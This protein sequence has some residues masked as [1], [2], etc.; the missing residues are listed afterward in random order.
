ML[1]D[2]LEQLAK[3]RE[4]EAR[5]RLI[6]AL[7]AEYAK[8]EDLEPSAVERELFCKIVLSV[9]DQLDLEARYELVVRLAKTNRITSELADRLAEENYELSE[10]VIES[11]PVVSQKALMKLAMHGSNQ[12]RLSLARRRNL[13]EDVAD[14]LIARA[15]RPVT[16]AL[17]ANTT[18]TLSIKATLA[19]L[20]FANTEPRVLAGLARRAMVDEGFHETLSQVIENGCPLV[21]EP[22]KQAMERDALEPLA[23]S[24]TGLDQNEEIEIDGQVL[25]RHEAN[26]N[27]ASGE[28]SFDA[29]LLTLFQQGRVDA[30][31]WLISRN[32]NLECNVI[33]DTFRSDSD[34]AVMM[35]M[36]RTG[37]SDTTYRDLLKA[38]GTWLGRSTR[39][40]HELV[41]RYRS[42]ASKHLDMQDFGQKIAI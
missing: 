27:I 23:K 11:S 21:P 28:L 4:P 20:I 32:V 40:I 15:P 6:R 10:P 41:Q 12:H 30:A 35:L 3:T 38:R 5:S 26:I 9:F 1:R 19:L 42:E 39:N 36:L 25:S 22:L 8:S 37:V 16:N 13:S 31:A 24:V 18:A 14:K 34:A 33:M 2:N 17:V 29:I 7:V